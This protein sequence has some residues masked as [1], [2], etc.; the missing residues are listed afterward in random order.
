MGVDLGDKPATDFSTL[1][2]N[3]DTTPHTHL[4]D[5]AHSLQDGLQDDKPDNP[6]YPQSTS[7]YILSTHHK[8]KHHRPD[9]IRAVGYT[10]NAQG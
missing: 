1:K 5:I 7:D 4:H 10:I 9:L 3:I 2:A 8:P 6:D